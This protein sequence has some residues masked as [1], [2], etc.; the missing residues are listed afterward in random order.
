VLGAAVLA[1]LTHLPS[2]VRPQALNPDEAYLATEGS[3][4]DAGG[5]LYVDVVDRKPPVVPYLYAAAQRVTG[6][7]DLYPVRW[8]ALG[9]H[10]ATALLLAAL[11]RRRWGDRA[12]VAAAALYLLASAG[13]ALED[14][15]AANFEVFMLPATVAAVLLAEVRRPAAAGAA[16]AVAGLV[17]Q[18][19]L[20][21]LAPVV[22]LAWR[23]GDRRGVAIACAVCAAV[24][25]VVAVAFGWRD[26]MFWNLTGNGSFVDPSGSWHEI[27][28]EAADGGR[29]FVAGS[30][31]ALVL[32]AVGARRWREHEDL[33]VWLAAS[34]AGVAA[35][36]H[37]FGHYYLQLL[38]P[39][40]LLAAATV[41]RVGLGARRVA[42]AVATITAACF[43]I[44][45]FTATIPSPG[46]EELATVVAARTAP[47]DPIFVWGHLPQVYWAADRPPAARFLTTGF[48]TG[49]SRS[50]A[51]DRVGVE[52]ATPG[53]WD[54]LFADLEAHPPAL[55]V[56]L[57]ER[58]YFAI[59]RFPR[60]ATW[61]RANYHRATDVLGVAIYE[62]GAP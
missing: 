56:D 6:T 31:V 45:A 34:A 61:L 9:A 10:L 12:A 60:F 30:G 62:R 58:T 1:T 40:V 16:A 33:W 38:P 14:A 20:A 36:F 26:F 22:L 55:V 46:Y 44:P 7:T 17:K 42:A 51:G 54:E 49:Y 11:A 21:A 28:K 47:S 19:G 2:L 41:E 37:F 50:R 52:Y 13:F 39:L 23:R 3:V 43:V 57:S 48:L 25:A 32:A 53:A 5:R 27:A 8:L 18:V 24:V 35:G 4:L 59:D 29:T 15:Q